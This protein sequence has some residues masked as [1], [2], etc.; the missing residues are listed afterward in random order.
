MSDLTAIPAYW[1]RVP[2]HLPHSDY[3]LYRRTFQLSAPGVLRMLVSADSRYNLYVDGKHIGRGP[4]R[5]DLEHYGYRCYEV[6]LPAGEHVIAAEVLFWSDGFLRPWSEIHY[7]PAFLLHGECAGQE[8]STPNGWLCQ[9]DLSRQLLPNQ[10]VRPVG[11]M[12][13]CIGSVMTN[14]NHWRSV[15]F[16]DAQWVEPQLLCRP[17]YPESTTMDPPSRW[18][19]VPST[20]PEMAEEPIA[21]AQV[22][23]NDNLD[24]SIAD[25]A[26][27]AIL[28]PGEHRLQLDLGCYYTYWPHLLLLGGKGEIH[29][30]YAESLVD[31][32]GKRSRR[33]FIPDGHFDQCCNQD[34]ILLPG[35]EL[36]FTPFWFRAGRFVEVVCSIQE[37]CHLTLSFAFTHYPLELSAPLTFPTPQ[38]QQLAQT[39]WHTLL[40]CI[41]EHYEDCPYWEQMQ[42]V[43]DTRIQSLITYIATGDDRLG[44]Q[45]IRQFDHS[46]RSS[47]ITQSRYPSNFP[48]YIPQFSLFWVLMI[49]D[50]YQFFHSTEVIREHW[51]GIADVLHHFLSRRDANGL[52]GS[53]AGEW[54]FSDWT[55]QWCGGRCNRNNHQPETLLNFIVATTCTKVAQL[56]VAIGED[57][58]YYTLSAQELLQKVRQQ[59]FV[60]EKGLFADT[61]DKCWFSQHTNIWAILAGATTSQETPAIIQ[62]LLRDESLTQCSLYFSFYLL[63]VLCQYGHFQEF[64][65]QLQRWSSLLD[66][67]FT[68]LPERPA[69]DTRSDCHAWSAG[70]LYFMLRHQDAISNFFLR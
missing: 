61:P 34:E 28:T 69:L 45:A 50:H 58:N 57:G 29:L 22:R 47:G 49:Y 62:A 64:L 63:E 19:L 21:I 53:P 70:P 32:E 17:F 68:T 9:S 18:R 67:G 16:D 10:P 14:S 48:Q 33:D 30:R 24:F 20:I 3:S 31:S 23:A 12:E 2:A 44:R 55:G 60:P 8:L 36:S 1:C 4:V 5:S 46:R 13:R 7:S 65:Q 42:Y 40:C 37:E 56:A 35:G 25:G 51:R 38:L 15:D 59:C 6:S 11:A 27:K 43:G 26:L 66:Y 41:H 39:S 54:N 52:V